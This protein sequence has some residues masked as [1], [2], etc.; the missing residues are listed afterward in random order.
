LVNLLV[1]QAIFLLVLSAV[2]SSHFLGLRLFSINQ[3]R[4]AAANDISRSFSQ[5]IAD[6]HS[7][8]TV[9]L[10]QGDLTSFTEAGRD[11]PQQGGAMELY[12][13]ADT[14]SFIRYYLD[15][16]DN[17]LKR[18][19][20]DGVLS[21]IAESVSNQVVFAAE[22]AAGQ[23]LTNRQSRCVIAVNLSFFAFG[24]GGQ[25]VGAGNPFQEYR[26]QTRVASQVS[27]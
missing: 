10:G 17:R 26:L 3:V 15:A 12:P 21:I 5:F 7:A 11:T 2:I 4:L 14:N 27:D 23:L 19:A 24:N 1:S 22:S 18:R 25:K 20:A 16:A 9:R 13:G 6:V 8:K